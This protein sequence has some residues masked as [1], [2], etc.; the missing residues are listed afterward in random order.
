MLAHLMVY[1]VPLGLWLASGVLSAALAKRSQ[2]DA[3]CEQRPR[4]A[5]FLK[6]L[7]STGLDPWMFVQAVTLI[8]KARLPVKLQAAKIIAAQDAAA[9]G[10]ETPLAVVLE[11]QKQRSVRPPP[12]SSKLPPLALLAVV[13]VLLG[14]QGAKSP[15]P[16]SPEALAEIQAEYLAKGAAACK[17]GVPLDQCAALPALKAERDAKVAEWVQCSPSH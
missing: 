11:V 4:L 8:V 7:R 17:K 1:L 14:C 5:G 16:C 2:I 9:K 10:I 15:D 13:L 6:L 3:W 12:P